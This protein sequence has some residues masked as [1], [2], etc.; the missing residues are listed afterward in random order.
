MDEFPLIHEH[1]TGSIDDMLLIVQD[2]GLLRKGS[3][4]QTKFTETWLA[5]V[6][7][8]QLDIYTCLGLS[9]AFTNTP[10]TRKIW[11]KALSVATMQL[12]IPCIMIYTEVTHGMTIHPCVGD[13]GFRFIGAVLYTYSVYTMYNNA[14]CVSRSE[15]SNMMA[16]YDHVSA[17]YWVPLMIGE[18]F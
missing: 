14:N 8:G 12:I 5:P 13:Q 16:E 3:L 7:A 6:D 15:L 18:V 11:A 9:N 4:S 10:D 2:D 1:T 17:G